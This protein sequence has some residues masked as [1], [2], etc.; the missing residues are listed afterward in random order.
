MNE[1]WS[2]KLKT[3]KGYFKW[4]HK[5]DEVNWL[6]K[7]NYLHLNDHCTMLPLFYLNETTY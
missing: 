1:Q 6:I 5:Y 7:E 2:N 4:N 3:K